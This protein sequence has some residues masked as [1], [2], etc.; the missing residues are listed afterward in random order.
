M[1]VAEAVVYAFENGGKILRFPG[2]VTAKW[3]ADCLKMLW[4]R[5]EPNR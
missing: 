5:L 2:P 4:H 1:V 3:L